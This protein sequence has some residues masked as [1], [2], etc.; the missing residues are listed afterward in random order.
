MALPFIINNVRTQYAYAH[1]PVQNYNKKM[2]LA[3]ILRKSI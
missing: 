1:I 2:V 3:K